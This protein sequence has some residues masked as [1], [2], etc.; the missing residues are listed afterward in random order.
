[1]ASVPSVDPEQFESMVTSG[2]EDLL[3]IVYLAN[4]T[5]AQ[6]SLGEKLTSIL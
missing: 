1:V 6:L 5:Q 3:M 2:M 4:I